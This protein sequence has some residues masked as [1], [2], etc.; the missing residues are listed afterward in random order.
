MHKFAFSKIKLNK[1]QEL[2]F[3]NPIFLRTS[4]KNGCTRQDFFNKK[5]YLKKKINKNSFLSKKF[6]IV[7]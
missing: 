1:G 3:S 2:N 6:I 7:N 5:I 4:K